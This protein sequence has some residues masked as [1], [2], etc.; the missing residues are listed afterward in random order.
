ME[1]E[2]RGKGGAGGERGGDP[3]GKDGRKVGGGEKRERREKGKRIER[4]GQHGEDEKEG[5]RKS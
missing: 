1:S 4:F 3:Y 2:E 5:K